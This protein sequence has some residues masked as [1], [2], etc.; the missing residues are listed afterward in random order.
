MRT[1][2]L[3]FSF[4][5]LAACTLCTACS[6]TELPRPADLPG[7][8]DLP[9]V[10]RIDVQQ[11]NVIT[12]EMV[13]QLQPGMDKKK[14]NFIMGS[15]VIRDTFHADRWDYLYTFTPGGG[16]TERRRVTLFFED[17]KLAR[18]EGDIKPAAGRLVV[19]TRQDTTVVVPN[20]EKTSLVTKIKGSIPFVGDEKA[21]QATTDK[22][23]AEEVAKAEQVVPESEVPTAAPPPK[24]TLTPVERAAQEEANQ[25]GM[26]ATLKGV[27]PFSGSEESKPAEPKAGTAQG[28]EGK[29]KHAAGSTGDAKAAEDEPRSAGSGAETAADS[30][31]ERD[32]DRHTAGADDAT[33]K[34][35]DDERAPDTE[36]GSASSDEGSAAPDDERTTPSTA[37]GTDERS[38]DESD[39]YAILPLAPTAGPMGGS[40]GATEETASAGDDD[41]ASSENTADKH[42]ATQSAQEEVTVPPGQ[43]KKKPGFFA[44]LFGRDSAPEDRDEPDAREQRRYRDVTDPDSN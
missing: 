10:H 9:F 44:R 11:G 36:S 2:P 25:S 39:P 42:G 31:P 23:T 15:P 13:A 29:G 26:L 41:S 33:A 40:P 27:L 37:R 14:V 28:T 22:Q 19:D 5:L 18:I 34:S 32:E 24:P 43:P 21:K 16:R 17:D 7:V 3:Q 4:A 30:P 20:K 38:N 12:Q 6:H 8:G 35:S 1:K